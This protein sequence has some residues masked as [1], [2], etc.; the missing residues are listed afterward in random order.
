MRI[1]QRTEMYTC[2]ALQEPCQR[3]VSRFPSG[4]HQLTSIPLQD[5]PSAGV[6]FT[7]AMIS[8][9][10]GRRVSPT[11]AMTGEVSLRGRVTGVGEYSLPALS[12]SRSLLILTLGPGGI[13]E[14]LIGALTAGVKTVLLPVHN[15][16]DVREL[17]EEVKSGLEII[18][19]RRV[20]TLESFVPSST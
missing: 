4:S 3:W 18:Y 15:R 11:L 13:K 1:S 12:V 9:F 17:P 7:I 10:S 8:M 14:K 2:I 19:V 6:A 5:G 20:T 16:K